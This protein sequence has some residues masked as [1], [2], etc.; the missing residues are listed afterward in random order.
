MGGLRGWGGKQ[1]NVRFLPSYPLENNEQIK[2]TNIQTGN[3][4]TW[5]GVLDDANVHLDS[6]MIHWCS[7]Q[8]FIIILVQ[9]NIKMYLSILIV[10]V[11]LNVNECKSILE[12]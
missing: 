10:I 12:W 9:S 3:N 11:I 5:C 6:D 8:S 4:I 2:A 7:S 1:I